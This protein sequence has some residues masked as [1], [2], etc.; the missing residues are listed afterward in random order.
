MLWRSRFTVSV[1]T[2]SIEAS[3]E[4]SIETYVTEYTEE[5]IQMA[6]IACNHTLNPT[7]HIQ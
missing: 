5:Y 1:K 4:A 7:S 3:I 6:L 2:H